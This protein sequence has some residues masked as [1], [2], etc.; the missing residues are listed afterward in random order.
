LLS[1]LG[2]YT[3]PTLAMDTHINSVLGQS[4]LRSQQ[5]HGMIIL[6]GD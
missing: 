4:S 2:H 5:I 1:P 6:L 3:L